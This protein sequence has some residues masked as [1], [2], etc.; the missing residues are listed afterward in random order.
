MVSSMRPVTDPS[1][2]AQLNGDS[3][4]PVTDPNILAQLDG[5]EESSQKPGLL[6][7]AA[8]V[9][10]GAM[11]ALASPFQVVGE[12]IRGASDSEPLRV[13]T[14]QDPRGFRAPSILQ[15]LAPSL[16][17]PEPPADPF[18][19]SYQGLE[20]LVQP[21][22]QQ[23]AQVVQG[24][25][26]LAA[27]LGGLGMAVGLGEAGDAY[28]GL[29]IAKR[30]LFEPK[31]PLDRAASVAAAGRLKVPLTRAEMTGSR[32]TASAENFL[33]KTAMGSPP[34]EAFKTGQAKALE[35]AKAGLQG[36]MGTT[37]DV[38]PVG[39]VAQRGQ[40]ARTLQMNAQRQA[41]FDKV[42]DNV[43]IPLNKTVSMADALIGE[44]SKFSPTT[45]DPEIVAIAADV[46]NAA[47]GVSDGTPNWP[48]VQRLREVLTNK[49]KQGNPGMQSGLAGQGNQVSR[50]YA[51]L[52]EALDSD[53]NAF[54]GQ[55]SG[56][57]A[58]LPIVQQGSKTGD[59]HAVF[60]YK[61]NFG[62]GGAQRDIYNVFGDPSHPVIKERGFGSSVPKEDLD[63]L[64]IPVTG[65]APGSEKYLPKVDPTAQEFGPAYR[66]ANAFSGAYKGLFKSDEAK[67]LANLSPERV[68][69]SV[70]KRNNESTIK[71]FRAIVGDDAF[72]VS[73]K[74]FTQ[75][76]LE[77]PNV[78][79]ELEKYKPGT[80]SSIYTE[81]ELNKIR[82][83]GMTQGL[84]KTVSNL[85]GTQGSARSNITAAQYV[86]IGSAPGL[87]FSGHPLLAA[88]AVA[89]FLAPGAL[90]RGYLNTTRGLNVAIPNV[91]GAAAQSAKLALYGEL[92]SRVTQKNK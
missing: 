2:L 33:E 8:N 29:S 39:Q 22:L 80:L 61:D 64:G 53:I 43:T 47:K 65:R 92:I 10:M 25:P 19:K 56:G 32:A 83:Y 49:M 3:G 5:G 54:S 79:K 76:L 74:K 67:A 51:R 26:D 68:V 16:R 28:K 38:F 75:D 78:S 23:G 30:T 50:D 82:D 27:N 72:Q 69:D 11:E 15:R 41:M 37:A 89:Q 40:N 6:S 18:V 48:L 86:G 36:E 4:K 63:K 13:A 35:G 17:T 55:A 44:Q 57:L 62:P 77:S 52:R 34:I 7:K 59:P 42:P 88:G 87:A 20:G 12:A 85:Q 90:A 14:A 9:G 60:V 31:V 46:Q 24:R 70:F 58:D 84:T 73:K 1:I 21:N 71:Q 45:R 91:G 81:P 66:R